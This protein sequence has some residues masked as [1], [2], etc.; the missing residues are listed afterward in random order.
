M[1]VCVLKI[2]VVEIGIYKMNNAHTIWIT[3]YLVCVC[4]RD[5]CVSNQKKK[6]LGRKTNNHQIGP[7][8]RNDSFSSLRFC[9]CF[10][11]RFHFGESS[12]RDLGRN[13][14]HSY[15]TLKIMYIARIIDWQ[16]QLFSFSSHRLYKQTHSIMPPSPLPSYLYTDSV[17]YTELAQDKANEWQHVVK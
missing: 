17:F 1:C 10:F 5:R 8:V 9:F 6:K 16:L 14:S 15:S 11:L 7:A 2:P 13:R 3:I 4:V 12:R